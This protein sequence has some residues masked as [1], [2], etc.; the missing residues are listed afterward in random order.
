MS[1]CATPQLEMWFDFASPYSYLSMMRIAAL[2]R[3]AGVPVRYVAFLLGPVFKA[4]GMNDTPVRL[5]PAKGAYMLRDVARRAA[6]HEL[7]FTTPS[8]F[9]R[10][11]LLPARIAMLAE[12][13]SWHVAFCRAVFE[14]NFVHDRDI[15][16][17]RTLAPILERLQLPA[18]EIIER[19]GQAPVKEALRRRTDEAC[20]KGLFGAPTFFA[21]GEMFWGDDR[22][23]DALD[24]ARSQ[25]RAG[26]A[27]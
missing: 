5:F 10:M 2:A 21:G 19:A 11:S 24:W 26:A 23:E 13:E 8:E 17:P 1:V 27:S 7:A 22:L 3:P 25:A 6:R 14:A 4:Q 20:A 12:N 18:Q 16:S 15:Q 9:P